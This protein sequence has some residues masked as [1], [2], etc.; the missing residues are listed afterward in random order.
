MVTERSYRAQM[1]QVHLVSFRTV[2]QET[3]LL[4]Q[5]DRN[6]A[7]VSRELILRFRGHIENYIA[8]HGEFA[9]T[10]SPWP[11]TG[12]MPIIVG[13]MV[14]AAKAAGVGPMAAVAGA[15]AQQVGQG[16]LAH[17][18]EVVVEN[19][20]DLF[21]KLEKP[22]TVGIYAGDSPLSMRVGI[23]IDSRDKPVAVCTSSG[24]VGHSLS[25][26]VADAATVIADSGSLADAAATAIGNRVD[27]PAAVGRAIEWG[28]TIRGVRGMVVVC[29]ETMGVWG[30]V[31][32]ERLGGKKG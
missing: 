2:V 32:V 26:G 1:E 16:L 20:G 3:D 29:G 22:V 14:S 11:L 4:I 19:G 15:V 7:G 9:R 24:T 8:L 31:D 21:V 13:E 25:L 17:S 6:L 27:S 30:A 12:P 28:Q 18:P 10:L 5:A 23:R